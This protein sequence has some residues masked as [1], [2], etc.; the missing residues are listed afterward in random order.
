MCPPSASRTPVTT[1]PSCAVKVPDQLTSGWQV[2]ERLAV[3]AVKIPGTPW[4]RCA[5][6]A[7]TKG[8]TPKNKAMTPKPGMNTVSDSRLSLDKNVYHGPRRA[9]ATTAWPPAG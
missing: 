8:G 7:G 4:P 3:V 6:Q 9:S 5:D 1:E 2:W